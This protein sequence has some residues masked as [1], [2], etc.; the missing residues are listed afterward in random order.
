MALAKAAVMMTSD[1]QLP[2]FASNASAAL[3]VVTLSYSSLSWPWLTPSISTCRAPLYCCDASSS[4][5]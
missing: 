3:R 5:R 2:D 1:R 4:R